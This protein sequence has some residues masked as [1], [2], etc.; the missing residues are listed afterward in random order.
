MAAKRISNKLASVRRGLVRLILAIG[1]LRVIL[2]A[3]AVFAAAYVL[4][5][6]AHLPSVTRI[7]VMIAAAGVVAVATYQY[8]L[9]PLGADLSDDS[10]AL[11]VEKHHSQFED[12]LISAVQLSRLRQDAAT[13]RFNSPGLVRRIVED[14]E[15]IAEPVNFGGVLRTGQLQRLLAAGLICFGLAGTYAAVKPHLVGV[16]LTRMLHPY[17]D[18]EWP[19]KTTLTLPGRE[20]TSRVAKGDDVAI[21]VVCKGHVPSRVT[22]HYQFA[23]GAPTRR[24]MKKMGD[25][26][27]RAHFASVTEGFS[28]VL[29]GG[30]HSTGRYTVEVIDRPQVE[31]IDVAYEFPKYTDLAAYKQ[32]SGQGAVAGV[33][34]T[35]VSLAGRTNKPIRPGGAKIVLDNGT[36]HP[37]KVAPSE[38]AAPDE[39]ATAAGSLLSGGFELKPGPTTYRIEV[40]SVDGLE[41]SN[42]VT[43]RLRVIVDHPPA[44]RVIEPKGNREVTAN[45]TISIVAESTDERDFG[46]IRETRFIMKNGDDGPQLVEVFA[47]TTPGE[48]RVLNSGS[49]QLGRLS[50]KEGDVITCV[51]EAE[52]YND[53]TGPG[54]GRSDAFYLSIVSPAQLAAKL[55]NQLK[56]VK[57]DIEAIRGIQDRLKAASDALIDTLRAQKKLTGDQAQQLNSA[58]QQQ[59]ELARRAAQTAARFADVAREMAENKVGA[60]ED[61]AR[62]KSFEDAMK[63]IGDEPMKDAANSLAQAQTNKDE[64]TRSLQDASSA[65]ADA[66]DELGALLKRMGKTEDLD[67]LIRQAGRLVLKQ[68]GINQRSKSISIRTLG[69][70]PAEMADEDKAILRTLE[71]DQTSGHEEMKSLESGMRRFV[72]NSREKDPTA[73]EAVQEAV[74]EAARDQIRKKMQDV[75]GTLGKMSPAAAVSAQEKIYADLQKLVENLNAAK[76]KQY[77]DLEQLKREMAAAARKIEKLIRDQEA[78]KAAT[79]PA[80]AEAIKNAR[81][82][83]E[84]M[85]KQQDKLN[86]ATDGRAKEEEASADLAPGQQAL[87]KEAEALAKQLAEL[88]ADAADE[89][90]KASE[91]MTEAE[92]ILNNDEPEK[93][94]V[95]QAAAMGRLKRAKELL[96]KAAEAREAGKLAAE[97]ERIRTDT[98]QLTRDLENLSEQSKALDKEL[99]K[100]TEGAS[101]STSQAQQSMGQAQESLQ[102]NNRQSAGQKQEEAVEHLQEAKRKLDKAM[103]ELARKERE[104]KL[105]E[106]GKA[107][108]EML[109]KQRRINVETITIDGVAKKEG[110]LQRAWLLKLQGVAAGQA[111]LEDGARKVLK[112][113]EEED[114]V[115]FAYA[116]SDVVKDM[117]DAAKRL[118]DEDVGWSTQQVQKDIER[119]L[120]ELVESLEQQ[121]D[122][123]KKGG[124]GGGAAGG[125]AGGKPPLVPPLPQLK[126]LRTLEEDILDST[127][128]YEEEKAMGRMNPV[129]LKKFVERLGEKQESVSRTARK[130]AHELDKAQKEAK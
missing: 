31:T 128:R 28:F 97:Q 116:I 123:A 34:G 79:D 14:A 77:T 107:L 48:A 7:S 57:K 47:D 110:R 17:S 3:L 99:S 63:R 74:E 78:Q 51:V 35:K 80:G 43:Y 42:P 86:K 22:L 64:P 49:W 85:I 29:E 66:L 73:A 61:V 13:A 4:D 75:A 121:Y 127:K 18:V 72:D 12:R 98:Q 108:A 129:L 95:S 9:R 117:S 84:K 76:R 68:Q 5:W 39:A 45:A 96:D 115:V 40:T 67:E 32:T 112:K 59:R 124:G 105:F 111:R 41:D 26:T 65:Q 81:Q 60:P 55:D 20:R 119:T 23:S 104:K 103:E 11:L 54:I 27:F 88:S 19:R 120:A 69:Q 21:D 24:R 10:L 114:S 46:G 126:M 6:H 90:A 94:G 30:D 44:V 25:R 33:T 36:E 1:F 38:G 70:M 37:L 102:Q 15:R 113:L 53:V 2:L 83:L 71:R 91:A 56:D 87:A 100:Q 118:S 8:V 82:R 92:D 93:A 89:A 58:T 101:S 52:D 125:A 16:F 122:E 130:F 106:I 62:L 109:G 50:P